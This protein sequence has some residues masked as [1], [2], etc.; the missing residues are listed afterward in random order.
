MTVLLLGAYENMEI[1]N[2][3]ANQ[4]VDMGYVDAYVVKEE[5]GRLIRK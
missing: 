4:L 1:A 2:K 3:V 5:N